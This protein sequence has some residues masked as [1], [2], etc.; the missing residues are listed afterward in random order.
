MNTNTN[1]ILLVHVCGKRLYMATGKNQL[2]T[3]LEKFTIFVYIA[4]RVQTRTIW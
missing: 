3:G 2:I 4:I 1:G